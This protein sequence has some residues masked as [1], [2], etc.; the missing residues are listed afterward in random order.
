MYIL[1]LA[2][3]IWLISGIV[4]NIILRKEKLSRLYR[5]LLLL[6]GLI[7]LFLILIFSEAQK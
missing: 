3:L 4:S 5:I 6:E 2:I 7:G 1:A